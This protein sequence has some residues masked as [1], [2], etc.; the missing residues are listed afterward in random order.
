MIALLLALMAGGVA[1]VQNLNETQSVSESEGSFAIASGAAED[2]TG[3]SWTHENVTYHFTQKDGAWKN[4]DDAAFPAHSDK[5]QEM[6][7]ELAA[8][9]AT[10]K[11]ENQNHQLSWWF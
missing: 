5:L 3:L 7:D 8:L 2:V 4:A 11:L 9:T 10:R 1:V 6:A